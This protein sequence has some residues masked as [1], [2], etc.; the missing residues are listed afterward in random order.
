MASRRVQR[1]QRYLREN[2]QE[3]QEVA[4]KALGYLRVSTEE[5]AATG[6]GL[7]AQER[8]VRAFAE[9]QGYELVGVITDAG[10]SGSTKPEER[11]GFAQVLQLAQERAFSVLL[12]WKFDR[13]ARHL[14]YAVTTANALREQY[15]VVLRSVTEPID[16]ATPMGEMVFAVLAGMAAQERKSITERTL[17]GKREKAA[18]GGFAGGPAPLGYQ[19]DKEG[20]L[21]VNPEEAALVRRIYAMH[22][23]GL[24]N[25][26]IADTLNAEG[27][28]GKRGGRWYP[29]TIRYMLD[30]PK[31]QGQVEY[32]FKWGGEAHIEQ[33]GQHEAILPKAG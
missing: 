26:Q 5:Q 27:I 25:R 33:A 30:N 23:Q 17:A 8:A 18:K 6:H 10:V 24:T 28:P 29:A 11:P 21:V 4:K 1:L 9:S 7:E 20:G 13:L 12:V 22:E 14:T 32:L 16:T 3:R 2:A 19:R 31:Y 15:G